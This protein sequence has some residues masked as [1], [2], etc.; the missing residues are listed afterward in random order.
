MKSKMLVLLL[1]ITGL[2]LSGCNPCK[3]ANEAK[4]SLTEIRM[5]LLDVGATPYQTNVSCEKLKLLRAKLWTA[6]DLAEHYAN[7]LVSERMRHQGCGADDEECRENYKMSKD[8]K[9]LSAKFYKLSDGIGELCDGSGGYSTLRDRAVKLAYGDTTA[10]L[11][12]VSALSLMTEL[13]RDIIPFACK[14]EPEYKKKANA[15]LASTP[16]LNGSAAK[17]V[18]KENPENPY[19]DEEEAMTSKTV[20]GKTC[21]K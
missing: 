4:A 18:K 5:S 8:L 10:L 20:Q 15:P 17:S 7:M 6:H 11:Q 19:E 21:A 13:E 14:N 3:D 9:V 12:K 2:A 16:K 1:S